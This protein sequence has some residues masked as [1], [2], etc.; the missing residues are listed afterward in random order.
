MTTDTDGLAFSGVFQ[1]RRC[2]ESLQPNWYLSRHSAVVS[3]RA[4]TSAAAFRAI[5]FSNIIPKLQFKILIT[6]SSMDEEPQAKRRRLHP[7]DQNESRAAIHSML[8][9]NNGATMLNPSANVSTSSSLTRPI[10]PPIIRRSNQAPI[11]LTEEDIPSTS[12]SVAPDLLEEYTHSG[13]KLNPSPIHLTEVEGLSSALNIDTI[14]LQDIVGDPLVRE[15]WVFNYLFDVE[16][17]M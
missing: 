4:P 8:H 3:V 6:S 7:V 5:S 12:G 1:K 17:L 15:C 16:F 2:R 11:D 9:A 10:T 14:S 13:I